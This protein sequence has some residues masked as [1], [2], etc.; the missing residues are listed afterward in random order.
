MY[1]NLFVITVINRYH[2]SGMKDRL[3]KH[4]LWQMDHQKRNMALRI[5]I[6]ITETCYCPPKM[7]EWDNAIED[8]VSWTEFSATRGGCIK[9]DYKSTIHKLTKD[10]RV[11]K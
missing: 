9:R 2:C 3:R 6:I 11:S 7:S 10:E 8:G 5:F 1:I 4:G